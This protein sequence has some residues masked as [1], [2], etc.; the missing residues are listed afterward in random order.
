MFL[1][2]RLSCHCAVTKNALNL[3][4]SHVLQ[5]IRYDIN[6]LKTNGKVK[7][8]RSRCRPG[9]A[10]RVGRGITLLFHGRGT[11]RGVSGQ[12]YAPAALYPRERPGTHC[13]RGWVGPRAGLDGRK[14]SSAPE[15]DP[16]SSGP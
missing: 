11:R 5:Q 14:I 2:L 15:F 8:Q 4:A 9:V 12:Q 10:Q 7:V 6:S 1:G 16:G 13:T 3:E